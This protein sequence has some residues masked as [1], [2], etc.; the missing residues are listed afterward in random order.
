MKR[1][2][3]LLLILLASCS[4]VQERGEEPEKQA[5]P[6]IILEGARYTLGQSGEAPIY[7][8]SDRMTFYSEAERATAENL[9]FIQ[10]DEEGNIT[11]I[12]RADY[13]DINTGDRSM[14][15]TG[16]VVLEQQRSGMRIEAE[17]LSFSASTDEVVADG[18]VYVE[19]EDGIFTGTGF[20]GDLR[21]DAYSFR[22]VKEGIFNL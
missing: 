11:L 3:P 15:L 16:S 10:Y 6:D 22:N 7:I 2:I 5:R 14:D 9:S 18:D 17:E 21:E 20:R 4:F 19:S 1:L 12:G 8:E 13:A